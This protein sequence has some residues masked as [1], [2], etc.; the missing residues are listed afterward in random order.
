MGTIARGAKAGGGTNFNAGQT[1]ASNEVNTDLN[2]LYTEVNGNLDDDNIKTATIPGDKALRFTEISD[3]ASPS[4]N[5][6]LV[7]AKDDSGTT[8]L[9]TKNASGTVSRLGG[10]AL[11]SLP[12]PIEGATLP[13]ASGTGNNPPELARQVSGGSQT[14]NSPKATQ[15]IAK[16]DAG[17]DEH[18]EWTRVVPTGFGAG[19]STLYVLWK[20][21]S[22][23][24]GDVVW[25]AAFAA[26]VNSDTDDDAMVFN[27]VA[28]S[29]TTAPGTQGQVVET[30]IALDDTNMQENRKVTVFLGRDA[31]NAADTMTGDAE[32]LAV[33][34]KHGMNT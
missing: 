20:A 8:R 33:M 28:T 18:L 13:D 9:Y 17:T 27:T 4:S 23:T 11:L 26:A 3:P 1:I 24:S 19:A 7:Y 34:L 12:L 29:T 21:T 15:T 2:T 16:F 22:A 10:N 31:D 25:K 30:Q 6:L 32:L 5:D 14:T